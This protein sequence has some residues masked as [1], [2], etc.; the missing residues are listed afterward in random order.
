MS[1]NPFRSEA[2]Y[3]DYKLANYLHDSPDKALEVPGHEASP[4]ALLAAL[5]G[6]L[7]TPDKNFYPQADCIAEGMDRTQIPG[8]NKDPLQ[9]GAVDFTRQP[10]LTHPTG[11]VAPLEIALPATLDANRIGKELQRLTAQDLKLLSNTEQFRGNLA[12]FAPVRFHYFHHVLRERLAKKDLGE[13]GG[14]WHRLP[15]DTRVPDHSIW[16]HCALVSALGS[17]FRLSSSNQ[18]SLMVFSLTPVQDFIGRA[19]KLRDFWTGSLILSWLAFEG[20]RQVICDLGSDHVLYP[21]LIGQPLVNRM[22]EQ[23]CRFDLLED[24]PLQSEKAAGVASFPNKFVCLV[25]A[26]EEGGVAQSIQESILNAWLNL[27]KGM[28]KEV[29]YIV[30]R[31]DPY[32]SGQFPRQMENYWDLHWSATPL[33]TEQT[34]PQVQELLH[35]EIWQ[36]PRQFWEDS[37]K[38]PVAPLAA[39]AFY[40][41]THALAQSWLAAGKT[42]RTNRRP[43]EDGIKC[44]LHGD[45]EILHFDHKP[46]DNKNPPPRQDP[47]WQ[48]FKRRP[49]TDFKPSERLSSVGL[50][51]RLAYRICRKTDDHPLKPFFTGE[52]FPSTTEMALADWLERVKNKGLHQELK[53]RDWR[54]ILAQV[55]HEQD[56]ETSKPEET[57]EIRNNTA[58]EQV[59]AGRIL[60]AMEEANDP[61]QDDDKYYA[62][63]LMDGDHMGRLVNGETLASRWESVLHPDLVGRLRS[64]GFDQNYAGFWQNELAQP[65]TLAPAVHA[66]IS[67]ALGDFSL[68]TVPRIIHKHRGR[69]IYAGGDDVCAVLPV[70]TALAAA[71]EI[72]AN[73]NRGFLFFPAKADEEP[74]YPAGS[75]KPQRGRLALHLGQGRE[76]SI[77][78][79]IFI[80]HHK[81]PLGGCMRR[82]HELLDLAKKQGGRNA[83]ALELEKRAGGGRM[84]LAQWSQK[85]WMQ[86]DLERHGD[87]HQESL[88]DHLEVV[89]EMLGNPQ[90]R[91][92]S[93]SLI[94]R[95]EE[96][97][98]GIQT[99][100]DHRPRELVQFLVKLMQRY[101]ERPNQK[102]DLIWSCRVAALISGTTKD[103]KVQM[104][105]DPL[106]IARFIGG[107]RAK[108]LIEEGGGA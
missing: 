10:W 67:E 1:S 59:A 38:L 40:G 102:Q 101:R 94:Y 49:Q 66:A 3:W 65:R 64:H 20:I 81:K 16:Q 23:E 7:S 95:L 62:I 14:L 33:V 60:L 98:P 48:H 87:Y 11:A 100:L 103:G 54:R 80:A 69:L 105:S 9:N 6:N 2:N 46:G 41:V 71:R 18:A 30:N 4:R 56:E 63:L 72:S 8:Y 51:K 68:Y 52:S 90:K 45:L 50:V 83:L 42:R 27:G 104:V 75:W 89:E 97:K 24:R 43:E 79:A 28:L 70:S 29:E 61:V 58:E 12:A 108:L 26:G 84:F 22:L 86:L 96:L 34:L 57:Q 55:V 93:T 37:K 19:R 5:E 15:A 99:L 47:F 36:K 74:Q 73:Y 53:T 91:S 32:V 44:G 39:G 35:R 106:I 85:P 107:R 82:A 92:F 88:L 31:K 13:L 17:C 76:I 25:P 21:S 78:A 77:S